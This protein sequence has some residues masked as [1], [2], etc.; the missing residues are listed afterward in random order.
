MSRN[1]FYPRR[2]KSSVKCVSGVLGI[3]MLLVGCAGS[4]SETASPALGKLT[5]NPTNVSSNPAIELGIEKI[6]A[7]D[8]VSARN[9]FERAIKLRPEVMQYHLLL[10]MV[11]HL[12][13]Q[14]GN[15]T[16]QLA[17]TAYEVASRLD[18]R[19]ALPFV[20]MGSIHFHASRYNEAKTAYLKA[21]RRDALRPDALD[22]L[23]AA[24]WY[25][26]ALD[27]GSDVAKEA[28]GRGKLTE[29]VLRFDLFS[30]AISGEIKKIE[31]AKKLLVTR[32]V[33]SKKMLDD[34][35]KRV[36]VLILDGPSLSSKHENNLSTD[37]KKSIPAASTKSKSKKEKDDNTVRHW[38][39]CDQKPGF[40][41]TNTKNK[42]DSDDSSNSSTL[43]SSSSV[44]PSPTIPS[45]CPGA[46]PPTSVFLD[47]V[48]ISTIT[49]NKTSTGV[50]LLSSLSVFATG[51][52]STV[53]T[54][55]VFSKTR[56]LALT[57]GSSPTNNFI[58]YALNIA[59]STTMETKVISK[60]TLVAIDRMPATFTAGANVTL[61]TSGGDAG[62]FLHIPIGVSVAITPTVIDENTVNLNIAVTRSA[63]R[64]A[65][66]G[67][68]SSFSESFITSQMAVTTSVTARFGETIFV[69]GIS[70]YTK[71]SSNQGTQILKDI[72]LIKNLFSKDAEDGEETSVIVAITPL[73]SG[74]NLPTNFRDLSSEKLLEKSAS[75]NLPHFLAVPFF[76]HTKAAD[77]PNNSH[78][79][80]IKLTD[81]LIETREMMTK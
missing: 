7:G 26:G 78:A 15:D 77:F 36:S 37:R 24:S 8:L 6:S 80:G 50:D 19:E 51:A 30:N 17:L 68:S 81:Y 1:D 35:E 56:S 11:H 33:Y 75:T 12:E 69:S 40:L 4:P 64:D 16:D 27:L 3:F 60:P 61:G 28:F 67:L 10:G 2:Y 21:Y 38:F 20:L 49:N 41:S 25:S 72:P 53:K 48:I 39:D 65:P 63:L 32:S 71:S 23:L 45:P 13:Y 29:T 76:L 9:I 66:V 79:V 62:S 57:L 44:T 52:I 22:G 47:T 34:L 46:P 58:S 42:S 31:P 18:P 55:G 59:N 14:A 70:E 54:D 73:R 43:S 5:F 74:P